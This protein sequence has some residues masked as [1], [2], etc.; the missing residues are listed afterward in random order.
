M[1]NVCLPI[2][3]LSISAI[4]LDL[5]DAW[6]MSEHCA[7]LQAYSLEDYR[8]CILVCQIRVCFFFMQSSTMTG[9]VSCRCPVH[10]EVNVERRRLVR[11]VL[12]DA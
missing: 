4:L 3:T 2:A 9:D 8:G 5:A 6:W 7:L 10:S 12:A 1:H 11:P